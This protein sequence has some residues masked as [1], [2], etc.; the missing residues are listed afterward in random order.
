MFART[1]R[2]TLRP[3]WPED[4]AAIAAAIGS[5]AVIRMLARVPLP[6][7]LA[8][9]EAFVTRPRGAEEPSFAIVAHEDGPRLVGGIGVHCEEDT[10][11]LGYW[12]TPD[13]WGRGYATEAGRAVISMAQHALPLTRLKAWHFADNPAS[14]RVL[15]KLG[16]RPTGEV[17]AKASAGRTG[18]APCV[19]Y[20]LDLEAARAPMPLAA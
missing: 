18:V 2:L 4:A 13:V 6:Y 10:A 12:L 15:A 16:F 8:D 5:E 11:E 20:A 7:T 9:A 14:A 17:V 1:K 3:A 19:A